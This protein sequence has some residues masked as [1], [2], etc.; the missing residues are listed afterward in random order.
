MSDSYGPALPPGFAAATQ[1]EEKYDEEEREVTANVHG[2]HLPPNESASQGDN[3]T[4]SRGSSG[5]VHGPALPPDLLTVAAAVAGPGPGYGPRL[6]GV[7]D[8]VEPG[9]EQQQ[10]SGEVPAEKHMFFVKR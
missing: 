2:P 1:E 4:T 6:P 3:H 10:D 9:S 5:E 8:A 7:D